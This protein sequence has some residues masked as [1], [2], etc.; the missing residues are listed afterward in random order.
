MQY[1]RVDN[2]SKITMTFQDPIVE[3]TIESISYDLQSLI[4]EVGGVL[5]L[6]LG[7]SG[8]SLA[9]LVSAFLVQKDFRDRDRLANPSYFLLAALPQPF[10]GL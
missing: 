10:L 1:D 3:S 4:S 6:T 2:R 8:V 9:K 5:G 7:L